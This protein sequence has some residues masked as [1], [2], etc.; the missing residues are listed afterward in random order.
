MQYREIAMRG[1]I[2]A[3]MI[4]MV[5][6]ITSCFG[7]ALAT[8]QNGEKK[9]QELVVVS[10]GGSFQEAQR[11]AFFEP[12]TR[13]TGISIREVS[14]DGAYDKLRAQVKSGSIL[15]DLVDVESATLS[16]GEQEGIFEEVPAWVTKDINMAAGTRT[17]S[18]VGANTYA[19]LI[20]YRAG[21]TA[22]SSWSEFFDVKKFP[23]PRAMRRDPR[24]TLE[25]ALLAGGVS[26]DG[27]YPL[28]VQQ[29]FT[30]LNPLRNHIKVWWKSGQQPIDLLD[31]GTVDMAVTWSGR[32]WA[33]NKAGKKIEANFNQA[34]VEAEYWVVPKGSHKKELAFKF[35][36]FALR[37]DR[38]AE[39]AKLFGV[40]PTNQDA[41]PLI[42]KDTARW[43]PSAPEHQGKTIMF[44]PQWWAQHEQE[45]QV[46]WGRWLIH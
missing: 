45:V 1:T 30:N 32:V 2:C 41:M 39:M 21:E 12:F 9:K 20:A 31:K 22:P 42:D 37:P 11:K 3:L 6:V 27:L 44:D 38:Q 29:A 46:E 19:T 17:A 15:W 10:F 4:C 26:G 13:E 34:L 35:M 43:L 24:G 16:R 14:Y 7:E 23:G 36:Q 5:T 28:N 18:G 25:I 40:G 8:S 33:A